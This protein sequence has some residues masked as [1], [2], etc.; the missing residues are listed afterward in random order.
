[1][2]VDQLIEKLVVLD[3]CKK[4]R[5]VF[6]FQTR[7]AALRCGAPDGL[8]CRFGAW[9]GHVNSLFGGP[10]RRLA[11][12]RVRRRGCGYQ[13]RSI[14]S[15]RWGLSRPMVVSSPWPG[16][17]MVSGAWE[18]KIN[19]SM[20]RMMVAK[21]PQGNSA[22]GGSPSRNS[23]PRK[24]RRPCVRPRMP[25]GL[26]RRHHRVT[27][28]VGCTARPAVRAAGSRTSP[29]RA[30]GATTLGTSG[31]RSSAARTVSHRGTR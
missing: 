20:E 24:S 23:K 16:M 30:I 19:S 11:E 3:E 5:T 27:A 31:V 9:V 29:R 7:V 13:P 2:I 18:E 25:D 15:C 12:T 21:S 10:A 8:G 14:H 17:T 6:G 26:S 22:A 1:M 28:G 4:G